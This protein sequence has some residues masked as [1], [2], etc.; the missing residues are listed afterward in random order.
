M[1]PVHCIL[2]HGNKPDEYEILILKKQHE[3]D[4]LCLSQNR[5][6][7]KEKNKNNSAAFAPINSTAFAPSN[8]AACVPI[9]STAFASMNLAATALLRDTS[10]PFI[11]AP[12]KISQNAITS[13]LTNIPEFT[14]N[15]H[16]IREW[17]KLWDSVLTLTSWDQH[18][19]ISSIMPKLLYDMRVILQ[20][21]LNT[22]YPHVQ[23]MVSF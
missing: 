4:L 20:R 16:N 2:N 19:A 23:N 18:I 6:T 7:L 17:M 10:S 5:D 11:V 9:T 8:L 14:V 13:I 1:L 22:R 3:L 15:R 21:K 12:I